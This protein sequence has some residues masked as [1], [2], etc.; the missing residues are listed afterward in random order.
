MKK[1]I[2]ALL[3]LLGAVGI[4]LLITLTPLFSGIARTF[5][6]WDKALL[7][8]INGLHS[9]MMDPVMWWISAKWVWLPF[10]A[11]LIVVLALHF[12]KRAIPMVLLIALLITLSDQIASGLFKPLVERLRPGHEQGLQDMLHYVNGYRGGRYGFMSSHAANAFSLALYLTILT[13]RK[14]KWMPYLILPW[15]L[16]VSVSRIYLGAHYPTDILAPLFL[17]VFISNFVAAI[18]LYITNK[19]FKDET[20]SDS[21]Y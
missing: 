18:Y 3:M 4:L 15:A 6:E 11:G 17:S 21:D 7:L 13:R 16:V 20:K 5:L 14:I 10:Y 8:W 19:Y 2:I 9:P 1:I 12:R